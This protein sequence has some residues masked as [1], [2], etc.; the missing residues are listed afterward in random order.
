VSIANYRLRGAN[1]EMGREIS[2]EELL[3]FLRAFFTQ[4]DNRVP[5][6]RYTI[7]VYSGDLPPPYN[8]GHDES[9]HIAPIVEI[10]REYGCD[11]CIIHPHQG[12]FGLNDAFRTLSSHPIRHE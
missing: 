12:G 1:R 7:N 8:S 3:A 9:K 5:N 10:A 6:Q 4:H 11:V 2:R